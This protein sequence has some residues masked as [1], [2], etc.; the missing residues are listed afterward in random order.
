MKQKTW[1]ERFDE[2]KFSWYYKDNASGFCFLNEKEIKSFILSELSTL[3]KKMIEKIPDS[4]LDGEGKIE[5]DYNTG[6][7]QA[8]F[9]TRQAQMELLKN[10]GINI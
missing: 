1:Q 4:I 3:T 6:F 5:I 8:L 2:N 9:F 7:N 10:N